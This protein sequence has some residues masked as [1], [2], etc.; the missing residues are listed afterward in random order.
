MEQV[1]FSQSVFMDFFPIII[2]LF[3]WDVFW[4]LI[5]LWHSARRNQKL[6]FLCIAV[7]NTAGLLPIIYLLL[8]KNKN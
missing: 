8:N 5:G 6:W 4:K 2:T 1:W 7:F 3:I